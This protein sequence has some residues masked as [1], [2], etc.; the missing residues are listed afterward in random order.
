MTEQQQELIERITI[1]PGLM[2]GRPTIRGLR[3]PVGDV[4]ELMATGLSDQEILEEHPILQK[5]DLLAA[6]LYAS[7]KVK[8]T[9]IIYAA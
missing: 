9:V 1:K 8:N 4:L 6:L 7:L 5:E 3:F 2:G